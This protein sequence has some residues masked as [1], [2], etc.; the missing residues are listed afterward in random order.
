VQPMQLLR[1]GVFNGILVDEKKE[2]R[3]RKP[4]GAGRCS[5]VN[6]VLIVHRRIKEEVSLFLYYLRT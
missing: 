4:L 5:G 1:Q 6:A 2:D 3:E